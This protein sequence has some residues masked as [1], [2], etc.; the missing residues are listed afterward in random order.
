MHHLSVLTSH[1]GYPAIFVGLLMASAGIP[2][3]VGELLVAAAIYA[4]HTHRL[5][6]LILVAAASAGATLG[7]AVGFGL[8]RWAGA[9][10]LA[11]YGK[12]VGLG[13]PRIRLGQ[14]LFL[15]HGGKIVFFIRF[16]PLLAPFGGVLA[17]LN[18]MPWMRFMVFNA[19]SGIVWSGAIGFGSYLFGE[20]FEAVGK[21]VGIAGLVLLLVLGFFGLR[22]IHRQESSLQAKAD[23]AL[24]PDGVEA[25]SPTSP[26]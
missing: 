14:Y 21:P 15:T 4:A 9:P 23:A 5:D 17:G 24:L 18:R 11:R 13:P 20:V 8:G 10:T 7:G 1:Y 19:L 16:I 25:A 22:W 3:P 6:I 2:L 12:L 26:G